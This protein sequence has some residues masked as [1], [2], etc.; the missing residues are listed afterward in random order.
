MMSVELASEAIHQHNKEERPVST[1][2]S[3]LILFKAGSGAPKVVPRSAVLRI[4][5]PK[6]SAI[7]QADGVYLYRCQ[8][9]LVP[10]L[11]VD[12]V[13]RNTETCLILIITLHD[14]TFGLWVDEVMDIVETS[15]EIQLASYTPSIIGTID[16]R[17]TAVEFID[18]GYY[19]GLAYQAAQHVSETQH[20]NLLLVGNDP[21]MQDMLS[22]VLSSA[23]HK[24]TAAETAEQANKLLQQS[25]YGVIVLDAKFRDALDESAL[26]RQ[27]NALRLIL[28]DGQKTGRE[29]SHHG[30]VVVNQFDRRSLLDTIA[31]HLEAMS[32]KM[33]GAANLNDVPIEQDL[34]F[35]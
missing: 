19:F 11:P 20:A 35:G 18:T 28:N 14:R 1:M 23:G 3:N 4:V 2:A 7:Y 6:A 27:L 15:G 24:V 12:D 16:L 21:G 32:A 10:V 29:P 17:G 30:D 22:P 31:A 9:K 33:P 25:D 34:K 13:N 5:R 26:S 8:D